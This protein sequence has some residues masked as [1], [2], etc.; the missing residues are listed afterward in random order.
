MIQMLQTNEAYYLQLLISLP[1]VFSSCSSL[2]TYVASTAVCKLVVVSI[3]TQI[4]FASKLILL[5][6][7]Q[8]I[9]VL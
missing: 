9:Y 4:T 1:C 7:F 2:F 5:E 8:N 6:Y 3:C